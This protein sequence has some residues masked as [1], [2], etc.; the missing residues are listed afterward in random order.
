MPS[1]NEGDK[2]REYDDL[3]ALLVHYQREWLYLVHKGV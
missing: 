1:V 2:A 3:S